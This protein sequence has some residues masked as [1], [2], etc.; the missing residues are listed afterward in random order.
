MCVFP[1]L[2]LAGP[3]RLN[4]EVDMANP[5]KTGGRAG[6][7]KRRT[8]SK[9]QEA[10]AEYGAPERPPIAPFVTAKVSSKN[11][12]TLPVVIMR[13]LGLEAGDEIEMLAWGDT[14]MVSKRLYGQELI[15]R[16]RG[17]IDIPEWRTDEAIDEYVRRE[18]DSWERESDS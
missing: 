6:A 10:R 13:A 11:Q 2:R 16:L 4:V 17:S 14:L 1:L 3:V 5:R 8:G 12:V 7:R 18:R 9:V 15:D